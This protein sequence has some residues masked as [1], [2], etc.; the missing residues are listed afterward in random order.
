MALCVSCRVGSHRWHE[1][2][3]GILSSTDLTVL[4]QGTC[5]CAGTCT[6][7]VY[8]DE[9]ILTCM[10]PDYL[11]TLGR[12]V[13]QTRKIRGLSLRQ[14]A[15]VSGT[16]YN[17]IWRAEHGANLSLEAAITLIRWI[18]GGLHGNEG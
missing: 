17:T 6:A 14:A 4:Q 15:K 9:T 1:R 12:Q 10:I 8:T 18:Q 13:A 2:D 5:L 3:W 16:D 11:A 7:P